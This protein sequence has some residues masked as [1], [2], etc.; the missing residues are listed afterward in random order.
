[1]TEK[2]M[3]P[4]ALVKE[5]NRAQTPPRT[6][7]RIRLAIDDINTSAIDSLCKSGK[8]RKINVPTKENVYIYRAGVCDRVVFS[9]KDKMKII[10]DVI[11]ADELARIKNK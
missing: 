10:Q 11:T 1:M 8:V 3:I 9:V 7:R 2:T 6:T 4:K 5:I